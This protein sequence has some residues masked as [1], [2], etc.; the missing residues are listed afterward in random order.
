MHDGSLPTLEDVV[1]F[2][3]DGAR[4]NPYLDPE[5]RP[6][7]LSDDEKTA[8]AAFLQSLTGKLIDGR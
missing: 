5:L 1:D 8:L 4:K 6:L 7:K 2:Y 3:S